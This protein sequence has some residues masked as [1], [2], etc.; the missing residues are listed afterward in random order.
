MKR[1]TRS[2]NNQQITEPPPVPVVDKKFEE[3][4]VSKVAIWSNFTQ[5]FNLFHNI[6]LWEKN[7]QVSHP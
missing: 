7:F 1:K 3:F 5:K 4:S 2:S 6:F